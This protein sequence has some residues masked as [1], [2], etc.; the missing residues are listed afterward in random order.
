M[1]KKIIDEDSNFAELSDVIQL[2][3][4]TGN[5]KEAVSLIANDEY[6]SLIVRETDDEAVPPLFKAVRAS[7]MSMNFNN[8]SWKKP[9]K[10]LDKILEAVK[11]D[12]PEYLLDKTVNVI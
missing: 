6:G 3:F 10:A 4:E 9:A 8:K 5:S 2:A 11:G 1:T 7:I 12:W